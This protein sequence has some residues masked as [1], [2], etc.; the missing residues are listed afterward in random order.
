MKVWLRKGSGFE[1]EAAADREYWAT[2]FTPNERVA[3][4]D[5]MHRERE[6]NNG[7]V[8]IDNTV[9]RAALTSLNQHGVRYLIVGSFAVAFHGKPRY[10]VDM[11]ILVE[12]LTA[13][14][15]GKEHLALGVE[16]TGSTSSPKSPPSRSRMPGS[17]ERRA[18]T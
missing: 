1:E 6:R 13:A 5:D 18:C 12:S 2:A 10:T 7:R 11:D 9:F 14:E 15:W 4:I 3:L 17:R 16:P 8:E